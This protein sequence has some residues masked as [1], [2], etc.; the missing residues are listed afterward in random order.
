L[1]IDFLL[2]KKITFKTFKTLK[3]L[4]IARVLHEPVMNP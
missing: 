1:L 2:Q 3:T 4:G